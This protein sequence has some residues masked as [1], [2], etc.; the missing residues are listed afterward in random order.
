MAT[1]LKEKER[2]V[3]EALERLSR[4][5]PQQKTA[6][7]A[8]I[9][10]GYRVRANNEVHRSPGGYKNFGDKTWQIKVQSMRIVYH[11]DRSQARYLLLRASDLYGALKVVKA[12]EQVMYNKGTWRQDVSERIWNCMMARAIEIVDAVYIAA[13]V[14]RI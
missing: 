12:L 14:E 13:T 11:A 5:T 6:W 10:M 3:R 7:A 9:V 8:D 1:K 2:S 4:A